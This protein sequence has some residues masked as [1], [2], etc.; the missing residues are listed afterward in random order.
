MELTRRAYA[1]ESQ[2]LLRKQQST[3]DKL[4]KDND[5]LKNDI[6]LVM[7]GSDKAGSSAAAQ[8]E[9]IQNLQDQGDQYANAI[10]YE[11]KNIETMEEQIHIMRQKA[12][13]QRKAMGGINASKENFFMIQKQIR[14]LENRVE[15]ALIKFNEAIAHNKTLRDEIDD[16]RRERVV[17]EN[18]YRKME[19]DLQDKKRQMAEIIELSN[20][21]YEQ[22]DTFQM[23][24]AAIEQANRKEQEEFEDQMVE[25]SRMLENELKLQAG[26]IGTQAPANRNSNFLMALWIRIAMCLARPMC[27][28]MPKSASTPPATPPKSSCLP[29]A[30]IWAFPATSL[31][32]PLA[33][34]PTT[35]RWWT[36]CRPRAAKPVVW[37]PSS[38]A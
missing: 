5:G 7:R 38:A 30:T 15:K 11:R 32:K 36:P 9:I 1:E 25:L 14:I 27:F 8:L 26:W 10:E 34:V 33:M 18:V 20:Q 16:L 28:R 2:A 35:V 21:S 6:A 22:R 19:R 13:H 31:C 17:F 37:P 3:V 4:R 12:T 23:E 29:C 24:I